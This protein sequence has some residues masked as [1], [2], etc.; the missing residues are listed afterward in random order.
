MTK[1]L[2]LPE[3]VRALLQRRYTN[4][5]KSW[6]IGEG[7]WPLSVALGLPTEKD[8]TADPAG[9]R[10]WVQ[11]WAEW[12]SGGSVSWMSRQWG[13]LG[14]QQ[15]PASLAFATPHE[16]AA[17]VGDGS[18]WEQVELRYQSI[19]GRWP[20]LSGP[21]VVGKLFNVLAEYDDADFRRLFALLD[22]LE[23]NPASGLMVRQL[24]VEGLDTKWLEKRKGLIADLVRQLRSVIPE[25]DFHSICGLRRQ[26]NRVRIRILCP[27]LRHRVGGLRDLE[28][29]TEELAALSLDPSTALIVENLETG[30]ALPD[31]QGVVAFMKL[32]NAVST[33]SQLPWIR[34]ARG[35]YWGDIDTHGFAILNVARGVM[36][37][38]ES[39]LMDEHT[40]MAYRRLCV[41][42]PAQTSLLELPLLT[43][44]ER[45]VFEGLITGRWG[46]RLRL[47]QERIPWDYALGRIRTATTYPMGAM[48]GS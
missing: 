15:L 22:W 13:R 35:L 33:L 23:R 18:R 39:L 32:G 16:V 37:A 45:S 11:A 28:A 31:L 46:P 36:P 3:D 1:K 48:E 10:R 6:L 21:A 2:L 26:P 4:Q 5:Q 41:E 7:Q 17:V 29:P 44:S 8:V 42:E 40:L 24:P 19:T 25:G 9:V 14:T 43:A 34:D 12:S 30:L 38:V 47:E 27:T 20:Q